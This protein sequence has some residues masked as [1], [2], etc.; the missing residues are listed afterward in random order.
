MLVNLKTIL[1][2]VYKYCIYISDMLGKGVAISGPEVVVRTGNVRLGGVGS[3]RV[4]GLS[5]SR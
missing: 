1:Y 2:I 4:V 5:V 3:V